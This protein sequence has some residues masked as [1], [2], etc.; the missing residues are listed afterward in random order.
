[1]TR[2]TEKENKEKQINGDLAE[3]K[4]TTYQ[5]A[6]SRPT[7]NMNTFAVTLA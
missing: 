1:M 2:E 5:K 4:Q 7:N 6:P 3:Q